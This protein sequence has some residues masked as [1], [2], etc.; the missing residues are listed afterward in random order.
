MRNLFFIGTLLLVLFFKTGSAQD[1]LPLIDPMLIHLQANIVSA[2]DS[3][4]VPYANILNVRTHSGTVTNIAGFFSLEMLNIDSLVVTSVG[5]EKSVIKVPYTYTG[6]EVLT[7]IMKPMSYALGEIEVKGEKQRVDLGISTGKPT[8]IAPEL[9]GDAFNEAPPILAAFFNPISYWQYYLSKKE[10]RKRNVRDAQSLER[11]WELHS[12]NYNKEKVMMLTGL[13][14]LEADT[15]M[16]WFNGEN[17]LPFTSTEYEIRASIIEYYQFY[18]MEKAL[19][20]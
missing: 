17:I 20:K 19:K 12:K 6:Y 5:Y 16:I 7:F 15:F 10:K 13:K 8:D 2:A 9:R 3:A 4:A 18:K 11:N 1:N 14:E